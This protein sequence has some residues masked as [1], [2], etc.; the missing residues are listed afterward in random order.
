MP[1]PTI[2]ARIPPPLYDRLYAAAN[3]LG[4]SPSEILTRALHAY[5]DEL[6]TPAYSSQDPGSDITQLESRIAALEAA[7]F[8][9]ADSSPNRGDSSAKRKP[10]TPAYS[11]G[12]PLPEGWQD[13]PVVELRKLARA[14]IG[15]GAEK[16]PQTGRT[17]RQGEIVQ[18]IKAATLQT[19]A[20]SSEN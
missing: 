19:P 11:S 18:R 12:D 16:D 10:Q 13:L 15:S 14:V 3:E 5:L 9:P 8:A 2:S 20:Y 17:L 7:V 6:Q 1:S 4:I